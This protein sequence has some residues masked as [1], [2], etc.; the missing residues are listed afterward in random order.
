MLLPIENAATGRGDLLSTW[1]GI[2]QKNMHTIWLKQTKKSLQN[3]KISNLR[4]YL[5]NSEKKITEY[6]IVPGAKMISYNEKRTRNRVRF[7]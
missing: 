2:S 7:V 3:F 6:A 5:M 1:S 4:K